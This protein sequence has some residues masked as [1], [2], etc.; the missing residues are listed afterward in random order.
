MISHTEGEEEESGRPYG[1]EGDEMEV[2]YI[3]L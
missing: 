3:D 1:G 2:G